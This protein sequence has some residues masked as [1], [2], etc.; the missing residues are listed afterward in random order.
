MS[1][2]LEMPGVLRLPYVTGVTDTWAFLDTVNA[3]SETDFRARK[4]FTCLAGQL[5]MGRVL[6]IVDAY[7]ISHYAEGGEKR[8]PII[9]MMEAIESFCMPVSH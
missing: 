6:E 2:W 7:V 9:I 8:M 3:D 4:A 5:T 1:E